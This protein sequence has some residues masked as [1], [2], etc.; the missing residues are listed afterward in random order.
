MKFREQLQEDESAYVA[1][2]QSLSNTAKYLWH[3]CM[4]LNYNVVVKVDETMITKE[5]V[6]HQQEILVCIFC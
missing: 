6:A 4:P 5:G 2:L 3:R 1:C